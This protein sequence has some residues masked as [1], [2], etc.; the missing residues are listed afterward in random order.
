ME[1]V[2]AQQIEVLKSEGK[3]LLIQYTASWCGEACNA[4]TPR[5]EA[6]SR[7][8]TDVMFVNVDIDENIDNTTALG[9]DTAPTVMIYNG[10][11]L[12]NISLGANVDSVYVKILDTL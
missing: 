6:L 11:T 1:N 8:Y 7:T 4:L 12:I 9:I 2:T 5:L 10:Y 3:K